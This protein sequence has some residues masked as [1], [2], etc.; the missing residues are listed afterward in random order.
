MVPAACMALCTGEIADAWASDGLLR[1]AHICLR[2]VRDAAVNGSLMAGRALLGS[3]AGCMLK[4][5]AV[6]MLS[7]Q[8][9]RKEKQV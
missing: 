1:H 2:A 4:E 9:L 3:S 5:L 7:S 6:S 8:T